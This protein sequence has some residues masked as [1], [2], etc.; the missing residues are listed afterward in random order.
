MPNES[1]LL[2]R[3]PLLYTRD[4]AKADDRIGILPLV[5]LH[6]WN[7]HVSGEFR[8]FGTNLAPKLRTLCW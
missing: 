1:G 4:M 8:P 2:K 6:D 3:C 5:R 7:L